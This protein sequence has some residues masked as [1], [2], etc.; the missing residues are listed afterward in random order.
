MALC[1]DL[2]LPR[3]TCSKTAMHVQVEDL[4]LLTG[5]C[6]DDGTFLNKPWSPSI[7][8]NVERIEVRGNQGVW[9]QAKSQQA[10][11]I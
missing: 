11:A 4:V 5:C 10:P 7:R 9:M 6:A 2:T 3:K 8:Q 1:A